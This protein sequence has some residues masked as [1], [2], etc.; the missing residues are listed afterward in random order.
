M[1]LTSDALA[2]ITRAGTRVDLALAAGPR[3]AEQWHHAQDVVIFAAAAADLDGD[4][5]LDLAVRPSD[6]R[7]DL[8]L[9]DPTGLGPV[10]SKPMPDGFDIKTILPADLDGDGAAALLL[11]DPGE[12]TRLV[13]LA[14]D[15]AGDFLPYGSPID[16]ADAE[17]AHLLVADFDAD[18]HADLLVVDDIPR[19]LHGDG[20]TLAAPIPFDPFT[21]RPLGLADVDGNSVLDL[22]VATEVDDTAQL[23]VLLNPVGIPASTSLDPELGPLRDA[24]TA[25]LDGDDRVDA[26]L[27][28]DSALVYGRGRGEGSFE[29]TPFT[30]QRSCNQVR[31]HDLDGDGDLDVLAT[32]RTGAAVDA[33]LADAGTFT[34]LTR[35]LAREDA[36]FITTANGPAVFAHDYTDARLWQPTWG[37]VLAETGESTPLPQLRTARFGDL[38]ADDA[39]DL[40]ALADHHLFIGAVGDPTVH[41]RD[42]TAPLGTAHADRLLLVDLDADARD[43]IVLITRDTET[44]AVVRIDPDDLLATLLATLPALP[45][46]VLAGDLDADGRA[47]LVIGHLQYGQP[48]VTGLRSVGDALI[49]DPPQNLGDPVY[50]APMTPVALADLDGDRRLDLWLIDTVTETLHVARRDPAEPRFLRPTRWGGPE[51]PRRVNLYDYTGDGN[52]DLLSVHD[53]AI[54]LFPGGPDGQ[55]GA[56][57]SLASASELEGLGTAWLPGDPR[58]V[59]VVT[60]DGDPASVP[61]TIGR[62]T[63]SGYAFHARRIPRLDRTT[64]I[65]QPRP[66]ADLV[67]V[68]PHG[69]TLVEAVP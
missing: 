48:H 68:G 46:D 28:Q 9:A 20:T 11:I 32:S 39:A 57:R 38:D 21:G 47:D 29:V 42:L 4:G 49:A 18:G 55:S 51:D 1:L 35:Q 33:W 44:H 5:L 52:I 58:P 45:D 17:P 6:T 27:C 59:L 16:L 23:D 65:L 19:I 41:S 60:R 43:D 37:P 26:I 34:L 40:V 53:G 8:R 64:Q 14:P 7:L 25:D 61:L 3:L 24:A 50:D 36:V 12:P 62:A 54:L 30:P 10:R 67:V 22:L 15:G 2:Y 31:L 63:D 13:V 56:P 66:G 69:Y